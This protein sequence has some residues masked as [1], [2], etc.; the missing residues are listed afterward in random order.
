MLEEI[1]YHNLPIDVVI[2][3]QEAWN[4]R[5]WVS[6]GYDS[7]TLIK[8]E[9]EPRVAPFLHDYMSRCGYGGYKSDFIFKEILKLTGSSKYRYT[10]DYIGTRVGWNGF[11]KWKHMFK[12]NV[13]QPSY[14]M[15]E[16]YLELK[17][18]NDI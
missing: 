15:M 8:D 12:K 16:L 10:R 11:F 9:Y 3:L 18:K 5:F 6:K 4:S 17:H 13:V 1:K 2:F 14:N 7:S